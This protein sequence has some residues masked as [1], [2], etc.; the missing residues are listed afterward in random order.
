MT[1]IPQ[2][3][4]RKELKALF[5][6]YGQVKTIIR[7]TYKVYVRMPHDNRAQLAIDNLNG[8]CWKGKLLEVS[9]ANKS[10]LEPVCR[11][12]IGVLRLI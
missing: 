3:F 5:S 9:N 12:P 4:K 2:K 10:S 1:N 7:T 11:T 8:M 6:K